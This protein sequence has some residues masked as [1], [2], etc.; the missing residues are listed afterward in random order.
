MDVSTVEESPPSGFVMLFP[1]EMSFFNSEMVRN[2]EEAMGG[3]PHLP[4]ALVTRQVERELVEHGAVVES[5]KTACREAAQ[6]TRRSEKTWGG[7]TQSRRRSMYSRRAS[8]SWRRDMESI[9]MQSERVS[10]MLVLV[11]AT[12]SRARCALQKYKHHNKENYASMFS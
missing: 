9:D 3:S 4:R 8:F 7:H 5:A 1:C 2:L 6:T 10:M 11:A 12:A